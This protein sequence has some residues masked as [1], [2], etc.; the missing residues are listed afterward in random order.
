M[1]DY[2]LLFRGGDAERAIEQQDPEKWKAH[3]MR[4]KAWIDKLDEDGKLV[5]AQPLGSDG[6]VIRGTQK[7]V[8]DGPFTEGKEIVG[9]YLIVKADNRPE[10]VEMGKNCPLLEHNGIIEVREL[11]P[12]K[13]E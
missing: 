1:A 10:A 6:S 12:F 5:A 9:G 4:W 2:L 11:K 8:T 7:Q 3:M 13:V